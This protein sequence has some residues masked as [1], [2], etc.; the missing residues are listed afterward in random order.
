MAWYIES[1]GKKEEGKSNN[2]VNNESPELMKTDKDKTS[3]IRKKEREHL[4]VVVSFRDTVRGF[5]ED[6]PLKEKAEN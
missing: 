6:N 5:G 2:Q 4:N 3:K 1:E